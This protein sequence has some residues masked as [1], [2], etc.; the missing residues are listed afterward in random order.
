MCLLSACQ[1]DV[2][3]TNFHH[4]RCAHMQKNTNICTPT[5]CSKP[6]LSPFSLLL[7]IWGLL[8]N[9]CRTT[10]GSS[11]W[12]WSYW[13]KLFSSIAKEVYFTVS[14]A[15]ASSHL[16]QLLVHQQKPESQ[17]ICGSVLWSC[18][19]KDGSRTSP[20]FMLKGKHRDSR[21]TLPEHH[22]GETLDLVWVGADG[23]PTVRDRRANA[24]VS[25]SGVSQLRVS[26]S[27]N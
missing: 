19:W 25:R 5:N 16:Q 3:L 2:I 12:L 21:Q 18:T 27:V 15:D 20:V 17:F 22:C 14:N 10:D 8:V 9:H 4:A 1:H 23:R 26:V 6:S 13:W 24:F 11:S 7:H